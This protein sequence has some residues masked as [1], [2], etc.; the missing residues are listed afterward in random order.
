MGWT[1]G[2]SNPGRRRDFM[3]PSRPVPRSTQPRVQSV[4]SVLPWS[5]EAGYGADH[6]PFQC[7]GWAWVELYL[8]LPSVPSWHV[9]GR[10]YCINYIKHYQL[11]QHENIIPIWKLLLLRCVTENWGYRN[12]VL[13]SSRVLVF[14]QVLWNSSLDIL[15]WTWCWYTHSLVHSATG[16]SAWVASILKQVTITMWENSFDIQVWT[17]KC[18]AVAHAAWH[19]MPTGIPLRLLAFWNMPELYG[20]L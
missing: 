20:I 13:Y 11:Y 14:L 5:K 12:S 8:Y 4:L 19:T 17:C 6:P 7:Q 15:V 16:Q 18:T 1:V 3:D 9:T 2:G 10:L